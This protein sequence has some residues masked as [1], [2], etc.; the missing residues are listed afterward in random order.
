MSDARQRAETTPRRRSAARAA[1]SICSNR[2]KVLPMAQ[3]RLSPSPGGRPRPGGALG[4]GVAGIGKLLPSCLLLRGVESVQ[5]DLGHADLA[6]DLDHGRR[7]GDPKRQAPDGPD[8]GRH[9]FAR[10]AVPACRCAGQAAVLVEEAAGE[11]V[12]LGLD[13]EGDLLGAV[14]EGLVQASGSGRIAEVVG[15][16]GFGVGASSRARLAR[17]RRSSGHAA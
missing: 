4:R 5:V 3:A 12:G 8:L 17:N 6:A 10:L 15:N 9:V 2:P 16:A 7:I 14:A 11:A 1:A 13:V